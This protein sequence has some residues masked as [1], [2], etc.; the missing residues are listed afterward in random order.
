MLS[1]LIPTRNLAPRALVGALVAQADALSGGG[2]GECEVVVFDDG[3]DDPEAARAIA[4]L[5]DGA[6]CR[7][8]RSETNVGRARARNRLYEEARGDKLLFIDSDAEVVT[9]DFLARMVADAALADVVCGAL[10][11]PAPPAP[12][13]CELRYRYEQ[14]AERRGYRSVAWRQ[15]HPYARLSTFCLLVD[16]RVMEAVC[17]DETITGYG[18]EDTVF[19]LRLEERGFSVLHTATALRHTGIN[20]NADFLSNTEQ[21]VRTLRSLP[22]AVRRRIALSRLGDALHRLRFSRPLRL[23]FYFAEPALR[24]QLL[25][26]RPSIRLFAIFKLGRYLSAD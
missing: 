2:V 26:S 22:A 21:A 24:R 11:N 9:T 16:R 17:F 15:A 3:S 5:A 23:L 19:G 4:A 6:R 1:V 13:G 8:V 14:H 10:Q 20:P 12:R 7:T 18:Y 25:G